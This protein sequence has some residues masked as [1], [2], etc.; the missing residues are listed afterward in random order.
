MPHFLMKLLPAR[1]DFATTMTEAEVAI[2]K[3]HAAY[4]MKFVDAG[5]CVTF[6]PVYDPAGIWGLGIVEAGDEEAA[7]RLGAAD[8]AVIAGIGS[9]EILPMRVAAVR[10]S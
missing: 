3:S 1:K 2:M 9:Y 10:K 7:R 6:G 5:S 8:P 4:W